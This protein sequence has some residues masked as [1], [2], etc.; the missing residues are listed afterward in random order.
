MTDRK[1]NFALNHVTVARTTFRELLEIASALECVGVEVRNDLRQPLFDGMDPA[2]AGARARDHGLRILSV[3]EVKRFDAW[4]EDTRKE[5]VA[6][7]GIASAAGSEA[8]SLIPQNDGDVPGSQ[9]HRSGLREA[10]R[11]VRPILEDH[12][13][14]GLVEPLGFE[15]CTLRFKRDAVEAIRELAAEKVFR[16][17]H[18][19]FHHCL[20]GGGP[21]FPEQMGILHVSGVT[22]P[23][24]PVARMEDGMRGLVDAAD[25]LQNVTQIRALF[26]SGY[27]GP[28]SFEAF[29]ESVHSLED[30][31]DELRKSMAFIRQ[32]LESG[33]A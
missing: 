7:A 3:A 23:E 32:Q 14:R 1:L 5:A 28:V 13:L 33:V 29:A 9:D 8:V 15:T 27:R 22:D 19:T 12:G 30:P 20:A 21:F 6:L 2:D 10:L 16:V 4:T 26:S 31:F 18:D 17:V 25:R 24:V 11:G